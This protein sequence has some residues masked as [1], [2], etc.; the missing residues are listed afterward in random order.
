M[1]GGGL[2]LRRCELEG[3]LIDVRVR[4]GVVAEIGPALEPAGDRVVD[5]AGGALLPG[6]RDHH[7]H[8]LSLAAWLRSVPCGPPEVRDRAA[9]ARALRS[10]AARAPA[11]AW[12]RGAGY[13]ESVA[14]PLD[15]RALDALVPDHPVRVQHRGGALWILNSA[16]VSAL[17][18]PPDAERDSG[19]APTGRL[20]RS[21]AWLRS[22]LPSD[23]PDLTAVGR[24][25]SSRGVTGVTDATPDLE[26]RAVAALEAAVATGALPQHVM[27]LGT[28]PGPGSPLAGGPR[29]LVL[30]EFAGLDVER[31]A[32]RIAAAR[33][34]GGAVAMHCV[35]RAEVVAAIV[36]LGTAGPA[37]GDRLEHASILPPAFDAEVAATGA[38]IVTQ[39]NFVAERGDAYRREV[40][41]ED[42]ACLYRA[43]SVLRAGIPLA[44]GTDAPF[45]RPDP[46]AAMRAAVE[47]ELGPD[48]AL[49]PAEALRLFTG[50]LERPGGAAPRLAAGSRADLCL[51][52]RPLAAA[53]SDL[54]ARRVRATV[55]AGRLVH[56][57]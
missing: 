16:A 23:P 8:L 15:R 42:L 2:L 4:C 34:T 17:G 13:H 1:T 40:A 11:G 10:A 7:L 18:L 35:T 25:L 46:W 5:A 45:G 37:P 44:A 31:L 21:D 28:D 47:R 53:L 38:T 27:V 32:G 19:G 49:T 3:R 12:I 39:P 9:L 14:G 52:D 22:R 48:E 51:L 20:R 56:E 41:P 55:A 43:R 50:P 26:P 30:D 33:A 29:K 36:A 6:L 54:D 57:G 24:L